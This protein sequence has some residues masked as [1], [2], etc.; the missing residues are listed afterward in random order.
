[1]SVCLARGEPKAAGRLMALLANDLFPS[2]AKHSGGRRTGERQV[3][4]FVSCE[5][6][7]RGIR[8]AFRSKTAVYT[9]LSNDAVYLST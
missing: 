2:P 1:M 9:E 7:R 8:A 4:S 3:D 5:S 6:S